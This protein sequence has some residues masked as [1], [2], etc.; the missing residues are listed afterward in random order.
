[1]RRIDPDIS[2]YVSDR[3]FDGRRPIP[4]AKADKLRARFKAV[5]PK[6][7]IAPISSHVGFFSY[8]LLTIWSRT[9]DWGKTWQGRQV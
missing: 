4:R 2:K 8:G 9:C 7:E 6:N 3:V 1:M 5:K